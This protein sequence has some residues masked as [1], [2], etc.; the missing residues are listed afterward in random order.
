ML[1]FLLGKKVEVN[2]RCLLG[3]A[4]KVSS[5]AIFTLTGELAVLIP[6]LSLVVHLVLEDTLS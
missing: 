4:F 2:K 3:F 1:I 5:P 6:G